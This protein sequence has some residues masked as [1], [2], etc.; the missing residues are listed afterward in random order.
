MEAI[1]QEYEQQTGK[2]ALY[3][4]GSSD[5][6]ALEYVRWLESRALPDE[7]VRMYELAYENLQ[8]GDYNECRLIIN[9]AA[10]KVWDWWRTR[11]DGA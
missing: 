7:I 10:G 6:H 4:K 3:R 2:Q 8:A 11:K 9:D 5:Y 1:Q